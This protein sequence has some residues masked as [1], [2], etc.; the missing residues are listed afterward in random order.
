MSSR[1]K[2]EKGLLGFGISTTDRGDTTD[3]LAG[4]S[5]GFCWWVVDDGGETCGCV[6]LLFL[7][8]FRLSICVARCEDECGRSE[9]FPGIVTCIL[10]LRS[11][12]EG[13][14]VGSIW[15]F[16]SIESPVIA[17]M[18]ESGRAPEASGDLSLCIAAGIGFSSPCKPNA[19][20]RY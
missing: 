15:K 12:A 18:S 20:D 3:S 10:G 5:S 8:D 11:F 4:V 16:T 14:A 2:A 7:C 6:S 1:E 13:A 17:L 19:C 9:T